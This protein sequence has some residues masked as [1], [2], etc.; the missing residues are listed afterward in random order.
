[1]LW[2]ASTDVDH[3]HSRRRRTVG[4]SCSWWT[5]VECPVPPEIS[6]PGD[7]KDM[8]EGLSPISGHVKPFG[9]VVCASPM[10][11]HVACRRRPEPHL[12]RRRRRSSHS[13]RVLLVSYFAVLYSVVGGEQPNIHDRPVQLPEWRAHVGIDNTRRTASSQ[14]IRGRPA[15]KSPSSGRMS[16]PVAGGSCPVFP[17]LRPSCTMRAARHQGR[18]L[19]RRRPP[20]APPGAHA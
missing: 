6:A 8:R 2:G 4:P 9:G 14:K 18:R 13:G 15:M 16:P 17:V 10:Q 1:M 20:C 7:E 12:H 19:V 3:A 5:V 11:D